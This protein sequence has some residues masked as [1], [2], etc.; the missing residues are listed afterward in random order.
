[1]GSP[2]VK[3]FGQGSA[4]LARWAESVF[5]PEDQVLREIRERSRA[6]GLPAI[7]VGAFDGLH[8]EA[9]ARATGARL[10][11][12]IGTLGGYSGVCLLRGM[13]PKG[14]LHTFEREPRH[15]EVARESFERA[16]LSRQVRLHLGPALEGLRQVEGQGPFDLVFLDADKRGYPDYLAWAESHL[17]LGGVLLADNAFGFGHVH[18][19]APAGE[20]P[21]SMASL[22]RFAERLSGGG[23]FRAT[24]LPTAE[25]LAFGV[26]VR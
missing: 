18:E 1:M 25:G 16:G 21:E 22:R 10:A 15:A 2:P 6:Q 14:F 23:R 5:R 7:E 13:G 26:K 8:L 3:G 4:E 24:M 19:E 9:I 20:D 11:V 12:E 17:R